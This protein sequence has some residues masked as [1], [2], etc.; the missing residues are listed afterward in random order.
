MKYK[1]T[2]VGAGYVGMSLSVLLAKYH[3]VVLYDVDQH[4][5]DLVLNRQSTIQD[6]EIDTFLANESLNLSATNDINNAFQGKDF[7][8]T[9]E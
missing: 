7:I 2:I 5:V 6:D 1:I 8:I 3:E 9:Q 4:R